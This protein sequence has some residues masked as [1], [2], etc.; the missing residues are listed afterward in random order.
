MENNRKLIKVIRTYMCYVIVSSK[1]YAIT[2]ISFVIHSFLF[3]FFFF[4]RKL[5]PLLWPGKKIKQKFFKSVRPEIA[6]GK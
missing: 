5:C 3:F 6:F 4:L 2:F 1:T